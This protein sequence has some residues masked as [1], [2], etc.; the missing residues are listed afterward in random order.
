MRCIDAMHRCDASM[1]CLRAE[2][3]RPK[4]AVP[5]VRRVVITAL[6]LAADVSASMSSLMWGD[7]G[8]RCSSG[9]HLPVSFAC[10]RRR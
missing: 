8:C 3:H 10:A 6:K 4:E 1:R 7:D 2:L 5:L 9:A